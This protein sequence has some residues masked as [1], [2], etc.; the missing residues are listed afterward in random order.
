M[1]RRR[2]KSSCEEAKRE[3]KVEYRLSE[4]SNLVRIIRLTIGCHHTDPTG[5]T[6]CNHTINSI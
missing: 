6:G 1:R 5:L 3:I 4:L 2:E